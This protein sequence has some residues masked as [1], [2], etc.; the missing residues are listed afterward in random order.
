[1]HTAPEPGLMQRRPSAQSESHAVA[2]CRVQL[3][4]S[5][6]APP[7]THSPSEPTEFVGMQ[8]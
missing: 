5:V 3:W 2:L 7:V 1:M 6:L 4:P 8:Y